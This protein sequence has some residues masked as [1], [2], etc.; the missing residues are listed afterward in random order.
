MGSERA[1]HLVDRCQLC[2]IPG[3]GESEAREGMSNLLPG[4]MPSAYRRIVVGGLVEQQCQVGGNSLAPIVW[5]RV[6]V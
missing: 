3:N 2:H 1:T 6:V 4:V 5:Q